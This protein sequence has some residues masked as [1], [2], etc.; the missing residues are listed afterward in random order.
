MPA[1][2][3]LNLPHYITIEECD[4]MFREDPAAMEPLLR[5]V[6]EGLERLGVKEKKEKKEKYNVKSN[7]G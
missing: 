6:A 2:I 1:K 4:K 3:P 7:N 5:I